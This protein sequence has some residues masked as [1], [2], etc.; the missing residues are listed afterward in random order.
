MRIFLSM[1]FLTL[2]ASALIVLITIYQFQEQAREYHEDRLEKKENSIHEH[3]NYVLK[4]TTYPLTSENLSAI[5]KDKIHELSNIHNLEIIIYDLDGNFIR[6]SRGQFSVDA[7]TPPVQPFILK[8]IRGS[9]DKRYIELKTID[10]DKFRSSYTYIKDLKFKPLGI[11]CLPHIKDDGFYDDELKSFLIRLLQVYGVMLLIAI[12][13]AYFLSNYITKTLQEIS[14]KITQTNLNKKNEK[15]EVKEA[16]REINL[17][18]DAYNEMVDKL[19]ES[20]TQLAQSQREEAWREMAKQVAHEIK[21][22]LTP[23]RLTVQSFQRKFDPNDPNI[24]QKLNDYSQTLIQQIDIMSSVASA[25]SNF[26]SMPAQQNESLNVVNTVDL[27]LDIFNEN[28]IEFHSSEKEIFT[29]MDRTQLIRVITNLVKN[30]IQSIDENNP[31][32]KVIVTIEKQNDDI[33]ISVED[34]G[35]GISIENK[36][37]IFEPKFTTK[38]S[39]MGLGLGIIKNIIESY[40]GKIWFETEIGKGTI[41]Y[42]KFPVYK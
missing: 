38:T 37:R 33:L 31:N 4:T 15:I 39:G 32:P 24:K 21:N 2:V 34:N 3:I 22:P 6:S 5:F 19:E 11:V 29:L 9:S 36:N 28:Y 41:F 42:V 26:A 23:M 40:K 30:A 18:I 16:S 17:V 7:P 10:E 27:A 25:F 12:I 13:L 20:A 1:I 14:R 8:A 35:K